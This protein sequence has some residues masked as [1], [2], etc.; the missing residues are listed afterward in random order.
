M[1]INSKEYLDPIARAHGELSDWLEGKP[2]IKKEWR[3]GEWSLNDGF[4]QTTVQVNMNG[5]VGYEV[6]FLKD[7]KRPQRGMAD[8]MTE[9]LGFID[10]ICDDY[11]DRRIGGD[12]V[13]D[14]PI[15][16]SKLDTFVAK[17]I[18]EANDNPERL[19]ELKER[20]KPVESLADAMLIDLPDVDSGKAVKRDVA[21]R[22][23]VGKVFDRVR[24]VD[25]TFVAQNENMWIVSIPGL[26]ITM[27][28]V[29]ASWNVDFANDGKSVEQFFSLSSVQLQKRFVEKFN[30]VYAR[31]AET[32]VDARD[33]DEKLQRVKD[34][35]DLSAP[36]QIDGKPKPRVFN[37]AQARNDKHVLS[38]RTVFDD[39]NYIPSE[40]D[41]RPI[42]YNI[43]D[44]TRPD[45][46]FDENGGYSKAA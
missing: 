41:T 46:D 26:E 40:L 38:A 21:V 30:S 45:V 44:S 22:K 9:A 17:A 1:N 16:I 13:A 25:G 43:P 35:L 37:S 20:L 29:G 23:W 31:I 18:E 12:S 4:T 33:V 36:T 14:L 34:I 39:E 19:K 27:Q 8:S 10:R 6:N 3:Q 32:K 42:K 5:T 28:K 7:K 15:E 2:N 24:E 11:T